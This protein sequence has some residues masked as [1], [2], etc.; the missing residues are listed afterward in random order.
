MCD[1][2]LAW[3]RSNHLM[4]RRNSQQEQARD[5]ASLQVSRVHRSRLGLM[6]DEVSGTGKKRR[7]RGW[8]HR[9]ANHWTPVPG[10]RESREPTHPRCHDGGGPI[11]RPMTRRLNSRMPLER[12]WRKTSDNVMTLLYGGQSAKSNS[13]GLRDATTLLSLHR[14]SSR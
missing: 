8:V 14:S 10:T 3:Y 1:W 4:R 12:Y 11:P 7:D 9:Q 2:D 6:E 5:G 13:M